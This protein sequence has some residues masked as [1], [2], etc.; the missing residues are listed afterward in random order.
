MNDVV[1]AVVAG[2]VRRFLKDVRL[3]DPTNLPFKVMAPV[4]VRSSAERGRGGNRV[5]AW[6]VPL[7]IG[8]PDPLARL[9]RI[10]ETTQTMKR[11]HDALGAE[12]LTQ[13][14][15]WIGTTPISLG[16]R[17]IETAPP[18][19]MVV[20]NV[21]GPRGT[22]YLLGAPLLEAH[23]MV[24]LLGDLALGI[25]LFS[26]G[27]TI[28]WGFNADWDLVPDLHEFVG[29]VEHAFVQLQERARKAAPRKKEPTA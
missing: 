26:Y 24:P 9:A 17:L 14:V 1:L 2:A 3:T 27:R 25:A 11:R 28:S 13:V 10:R 22:L 29:A 5:A 8:E 21:P 15:E 4:S 6:F 18:F 20:T 23:P 12:T 19:N 16:A 7:P